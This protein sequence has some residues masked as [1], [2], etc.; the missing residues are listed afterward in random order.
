MITNSFVDITEHR[1]DTMVFSV[2]EPSHGVE[3]K[4]TIFFYHGWGSD[5]EKQ[6]FRGT[7]FATYGYRVILPCARDHGKRGTMDY[8]DD[9][10][11]RRHLPR[12]IMHNIEEFPSLLR[13]CEANFG[14]RAERTVISGHS[15]G[16]LTASALFTFKEDLFAATLFNGLCDWTDVIEAMADDYESQRMAEFL[17]AVN[18]VKNKE[19]LVDRYLFMHNGAEDP[20]ISAKAQQAF[21]DMMVEDYTKKERI[22]CTLW[23]DTTHQLT[24]QMLETALSQWSE[25]FNN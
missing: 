1:L 16:A 11:M 21:Y 5:H 9:E 19:K 23:D 22:T 14:V 6:Y 25:I 8:D 17:A 13:Y 15:M 12:I 24:T 18:P 10:V 4:G 20:V 2:V 3:P 7:I